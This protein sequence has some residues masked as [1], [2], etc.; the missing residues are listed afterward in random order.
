MSASGLQT[1]YS[2]PSLGFRFE[3]ERSRVNV[4]LTDRSGQTIHRFPIRPAAPEVTPATSS[5]VDMRA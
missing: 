2:P 1:T 3:M 4:V 5:R